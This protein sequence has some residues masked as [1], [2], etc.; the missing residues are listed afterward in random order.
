MTNASLE[1]LRKQIDAIDNDIISL[2]SK[3]MEIVEKIGSYKKQNNLPLMD[4][5][6]WQTLLTSL[7]QKAD[8][9]N[10]PKDLIK[11]IYEQIHRHALCIEE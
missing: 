4:S 11:D 8:T 3:R 5:A 7:L 10:L 1:S 2:L 9:L 6:R